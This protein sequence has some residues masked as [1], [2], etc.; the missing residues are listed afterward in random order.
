MMI[1]GTVLISIGV[2]FSFLGALGL[3]RMKD[4]YNRLQTSTKA[5]T[6]G[7]FSTIIGVGFLNPV[8]LPKTIIIALFIMIT[9]PIASH[10]L[11]RASHK[12]GA[13]MAEETTDDAYAKTENS[14]KE[15]E[16]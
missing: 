16:K 15:E 12:S 6:L 2:I 8:W 13:R 4:I 5:T 9:S 3:I 7:A 1:I 11:A 10:A 14:A